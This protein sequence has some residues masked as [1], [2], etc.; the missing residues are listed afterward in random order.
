ML[1]NAGYVSSMAMKFRADVPTITMSRLKALLTGGIPTF[2]DIGN[3]FSA[4]ALDEDNL[5]EQMITAGR[6]VAFMGDDTWMQMA[7]N[8]FSAGAFP[9]P[10]FNVL[11]LHSVDEG[12]W[13]HL[14]SYLLD[15]SKQSFDFLI[16]HFL[17]VDHAGHA[18]GVKSKEM[19]E[20]LTQLDSWI[21]QIAEMMLEGSGPGGLYEHSLLLV[22]G[23][24][25]QTLS[26]DHGGGSTEETDT[27]LLAFNMGKWWQVREEGDMRKQ[28]CRGVGDREANLQGSSRCSKTSAKTSSGTDSPRVVLDVLPEAQEELA[29]SSVVNVSLDTS[30]LDR[31]SL[32]IEGPWSTQSAAKDLCS[33]APPA[34]SPSTVARSTEPGSPDNLPQRT[35]VQV[36]TS[37][38]HTHI[39]L[40]PQVDFAAS[41]AVSLGLPIPFGNIGR[42]DPSWWNMASPMAPISPMAPKTAAAIDGTSSAAVD[43]TS[44]AAVDG[45][46]SAAVDG[47]SS[48]AIDGTSSAAIDG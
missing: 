20:K 30:G 7:P 29:L 37:S 47:T 41:L 48:V 14:P 18:H 12:V 40:M 5:L 44:S 10:S 24:H 22:L 32:L 11:D 27:L 23:D 42:I 15:P 34:S 45:T 16:G 35:S 9:F 4:T 21:E 2:L 13:Q 6:K 1:E 25:G 26:G 28:A 3:S 39:G 17:G 33:D 19:E 36:V 43:G 31:I 46:S 8:A 38:R